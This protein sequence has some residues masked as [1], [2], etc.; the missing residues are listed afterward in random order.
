LIPQRNVDEA[1]D[2]EWCVGGSGGGG[3]DQIMS[4]Q[5]YA[6]HILQ[7]SQKCGE[8]HKQVAYLRTVDRHVALLE[9]PHHRHRHATFDAAPVFLFDSL[10]SWCL[11]NQK[12]YFKLNAARHHLCLQVTGQRNKNTRFVGKKAQW[13][14]VSVTG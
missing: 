8:S 6:T 12:T 2:T 11:P 1:A 10:P 9:A 5:V 13:S 14:V 4:R 3:E 7:K